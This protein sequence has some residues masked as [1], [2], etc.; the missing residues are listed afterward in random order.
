MTLVPHAKKLGLIDNKT[1]SIDDERSGIRFVV[2]RALRKRGRGVAIR[3]MAIRRCDRRHRARGAP[4]LPTRQTGSR[5]P[6]LGAARAPGPTGSSRDTYA[7]ARRA[8][9]DALAASP[10]SMRSWRDVRAPRRRRRPARVACAGPRPALADVQ[11]GMARAA[12]AGDRPA[13]WL[14]DRF[15][16]APGV[17]DWRAPP[18]C[19][20]SRAAIAELAQRRRTRWLL[21]DLGSRNGTRLNGEPGR[22]TEIDSYGRAISSARCGVQ[23]PAAPARVRTFDIRFDVQCRGWTRLSIEQLFQPDDRGASRAA[24]SRPPSGR[25]GSPAA[26]R[27]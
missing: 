18:E 22:S 10:S 4:R 19:D 24:S 12:P 27:A 2:P 15:G 16:R 17:A 9:P 11:R 3:R 20:A 21:R 6:L 23:L 25:S 26:R 5:V 13:G 1:C 7:A 14:A 8:S